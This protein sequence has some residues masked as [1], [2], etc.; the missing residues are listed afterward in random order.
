M[1][2]S[3][4]SCMLK[5]MKSFEHSYLIKNFV[6][7]WTIKLRQKIS[8]FQNEKKVEKTSWSEKEEQHTL[9]W[10]SWSHFNGRTWVGETIV[11][12]KLRFQNYTLV[13]CSHS[14]LT[15]WAIK[16]ETNCAVQEILVIHAIGV[17]VNPIFYAYSIRSWPVRQ[18]SK[19]RLTQLG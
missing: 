9:I 13:G 7:Q 14:S 6:H 12:D 5:K 10:K 19:Y 11:N 16:N 4:Y 18:L 2:T 15:I 8:F 17:K 3:V 1:K